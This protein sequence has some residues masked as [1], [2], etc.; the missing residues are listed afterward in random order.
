DA[1]WTEI[2]KFGPGEFTA[3]DQLPLN[4]RQ[5]LASIPTLEAT[6]RNQAATN[7]AQVDARRAADAAEAK[8]E[9]AHSA[10]LDLMELA[11]SNPGEF[12]KIDLRTHPDL[13]HDDRVTLMS[14]QEAYRNS[15]KPGQT[16]VVDHDR[17]RTEINR[18]APGVGLDTKDD[19]D[20]V[21][22]GK[23]YDQAIT[24]AQTLLKTNGSKPLS[25][26]QV[27][28]I[29][30]AVMMPVTIKEARPLWGS[31]SK[32]LPRFEAERRRRELGDKYGGDSYR[33][34]D[35]VRADIQMKEGRVPSDAEIREKMAIIS[36]GG[37]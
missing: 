9:A 28:G 3:Y 21:R 24:M 12:D 19:K 31:S 5:Q 10:E 16:S 32:V 25:D 35:L 14:K 13:T 26:A 17:V 2:N 7:Q 33:L 20:R 27:E 23:A 15:K 22:L 4:I 29:A 6:F 8:T 18:F 37:R 34:Y 11:Y 1:A 30:R 36:R